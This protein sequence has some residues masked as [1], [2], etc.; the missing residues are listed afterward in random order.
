[1][2]ALKQNNKIAG[3]CAK[4]KK[5][6]YLAPILRTYGSIGELTAGGPGSKADNKSQRKK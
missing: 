5:A 6:S 2:L 1:M 3:V 4:P